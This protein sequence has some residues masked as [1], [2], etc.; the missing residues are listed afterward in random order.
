MPRTREEIQLDIDTCLVALA[1]LR[2]G[3]QIAEFIVGTG[4]SQRRY[5]YNAVTAED[6]QRD[7]NLFRREL[8]ALGDP[9]GAP[10]TFRRHTSLAITI[11]KITD[12][13]ATPFGEY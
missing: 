7:L 4:D 10:M 11:P 8:Q 9:E 2:A 3:K 12:D 1:D 13:C 5:K 6:L